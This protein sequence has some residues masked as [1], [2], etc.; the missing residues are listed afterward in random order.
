MHTA[1][2]R[3]HAAP[4]HRT[5]RVCFSALLALSASVAA[6]VAS[7]QL[8]TKGRLVVELDR[9]FGPLQFTNDLLIPVHMETTGDGSGRLFY[10]TQVGKVRSFQNGVFTTFLDISSTSTVAD[11]VA[12]TGANGL[13]GSAF[14]PGYTDPLSPGY[15]KFYTFHS[16]S[17]NPAE[18]PDFF[19]TGG[20]LTHHS[21]LTEWTTDANNP[22][23]IDLST[24]REIFRSEHLNNIHFGGMVDFGPDGYLYTAIGTPTGAVAPQ[25]Q[26]VTKHFGKIFR[27]DPLNPAATPGSTDPIGA[28]GQYRIPVSNPYVGVTGLDEIFAL[29]VRNPYRFTVDPVSEL[30]FAGDVGE[31]SREEV[32]AFG[33][34]ANLGWPHREGSAAGPIASP[35]PAPPFLDPI[36]EYLHGNPGDGRSITGGYVYRGSIPELQGKYVFGEFSYGIGQFFASA[37]RLFWIDPFD[38]NGNLK[39]FDENEIK[40]FRLGTATRAASLNLPADSDDLDFTLYG[41]GLDDEGEIYAFGTRTGGNRAISYKIASAIDLAGD[42]SGN[43]IVSGDDL[44][45]LTSNFGMTG[46]DFEDGDSDGDGRVDGTDFLAWQRTVG[47]DFSPPPATT[48]V[49]EPSTLAGSMIVLGLVATIGRRATR[50]R[51]A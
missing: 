39:D 49:P 33:N 18:T 5:A 10:T 31:A 30:V 25:A 20:T 44:T 43:G 40:E 2:S 23:Q 34:G 27:I 47:L 17:V 22:L 9:N 7:G 12:L 32:S 13:L 26:D 4:C 35:V 1:I 15:R 8:I 45:I 19:G 16:T 14:H 37:G 46:A 42:F 21:I 41:F 6:D 38:A 48:A 50:R 11:K 29:G 24:R 36:A 3:G 28:N 51:A